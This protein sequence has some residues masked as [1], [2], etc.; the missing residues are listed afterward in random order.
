MTDTALNAFDPPRRRVRS[1][2][3]REI[4]DFIRAQ[5]FTGQLRAGERINQDALALEFGVSRLPV[6]EALITLEGEGM[7]RSELHRGAYVIPITRDDIE[8]HYMVYG[9]IQ[10]LAA[11]R[12]APAL[13]EEHFTQL[14]RLNDELSRNP[15]PEQVSDLDWQF[16]SVINRVGGSTRLLSVLRQLGRSLPQSLYAMPPKVSALAIVEHDGILE[17]LRARDPRAAAERVSAHTTREG[18]YLAQ[19]LEENGVLSP[20]VDA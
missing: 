18:G 4:V 16:H 12:A 3:S 15:D 11:S 17:A 10:G 20:S 13:T 1:T 14:S 19:L 6:R 9:Y 8:D 2:T 7:V 5:I